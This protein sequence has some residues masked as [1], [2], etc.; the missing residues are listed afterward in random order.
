[1]ST[2]IVLGDDLRMVQSSTKTV[3]YIFSPIWRVVV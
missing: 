3:D 1:M 2:N